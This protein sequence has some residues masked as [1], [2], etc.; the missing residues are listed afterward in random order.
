MDNLTHKKVS[1]RT[2]AAGVAWTVPAVAV[3][4]AVP[5]FASSSC[6][7]VVDYDNVCKYPGKKGSVKQAYMVKLTLRNTTYKAV[8][9]STK[10]AWISFTDGKTGDGTPLLYL[11]KPDDDVLPQD[12]VR[13]QPGEARVVYFVLND[14]GNSANRA[15]EFGGT[16]AV[17][18]DSDVQG[19]CLDLNLGP[20]QFAATPPTCAG[21]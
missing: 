16:L 18:R 10:D 7:T 4:T 8:T 3:A 15:G 19:E 12:S 20:F 6:A 9:I 2:V 11:E 17:D 14:M 1:R 13:I 21:L 5:A